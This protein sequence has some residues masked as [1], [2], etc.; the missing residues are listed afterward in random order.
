MSSVDLLKEENKNIEIMIVEDSP[1][2]ALTLQSMLE[3][4]GY[5]VV[6]SVNGLDALARIKKHPVQ[7]VITDIMMP[8]MDGYQLSREIKADA[9]LKHIPVMLLTQ[10]TEP[11]DIVKGLES[12]A[13]NFVTKPYKPEM[14]L[15]RIRYVL[16]NQE[17][18]KKRDTSV[19]IEIFFAGSRHFINSDRIQMLDLLLSTYEVGIQQKRELQR[20]NRELHEALDT[21]KKLQGILPICANCKKIRDEDNQW[22][23]MEKYIS[24]RS[25]ARFSHGIC[26]ECAKKLY[27][28]FDLLE[29]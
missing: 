13:N 23:L 12:G 25:D 19:G 1:T 24:Q 10:L 2:Q 29:K 8:K 15:S 22:H 17:I 3:E 5:R 20:V 9:I 26:P 16:I 28:D 11:E 4:H 14:L 7:L 6:T 27:P 18:R 21:V